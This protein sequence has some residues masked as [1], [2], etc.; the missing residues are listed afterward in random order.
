MTILLSVILVI[1]GIM[2][3]SVGMLSRREKTKAQSV[4]KLF[5][6]VCLGSALWC[7]GYA[8]MAIAPQEGSAYLLRAVALF[9]VFSC[10]ASIVRYTQ[11]MSGIYF[12]HQKAFVIFLICGAIICFVLVALPGA[13]TFVDTAYGRYYVFN[14]WIGRYTQYAYLLSLFAACL[15]MSYVWKK[16]AR[17]KREKLMARYLM[18]SSIVISA[19]AFFDTIFPLFKMPA[20]PSSAISTFI[21]IQIL[22]V[23]LK[24]YNATSVS[25]VGVSEY[26]FKTI[27]TPVIIMNE[28]M[29]IFDCNDMACGY[30]AGTK[31]EIIGSSAADWLRYMNPAD[32]ERLRVEIL[33][34]SEEI[35]V[36]TMVRGTGAACSMVSTPVYD[37]FGELLCIISILNDNT[38]YEKIRRQ[39]RESTRRAELSEAA[40]KEF[41][42]RIDK[43]I[44]API[45]DDV[46]LIEALRAGDH[47][48]SETESERMDAVLASNRDLIRSMD[49]LL[50]LSCIR[51]GDFALAHHKFD[52]EELLVE[53]FSETAETID[54]SRV[55]LITRIS[56]SV[57]KILTGDRTRLKYIFASILQNAVR[58]TNL[59]RI[60]FQL[61]CE[62][63]FGNV[64]LHVKI[65]DTGCGINEEELDSIFGMQDE[66]G[67]YIN[68][69]STLT[70]AL[71]SKLIKMMNGRIS[72]RSSVGTGTTVSFD[73]ELHTDDELGIVPYGS[74]RQKALVIMDDQYKSEAVAYTLKE[75]GMNCETMIRERIEGANL[76]EDDKVSLVLVG[77][78]ILT[79]MRAYLHQAYKYARLVPV[80]SYKNYKLLEPGDEGVCGTLLFSQIKEV[81]KR[82]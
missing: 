17:H 77:A 78:G 63:S 44:K 61:T 14:P 67:N 1:L 7:I 43:K 53:V 9:G 79:R 39:A 21:Y 82:R 3:V 32:A 48:F 28:D 80:Y 70:L 73:I 30:L 81:L 18:I 37:K 23:G 16:R 54:E 69:G 34:Q 56:P 55:R 36:R 29:S 49:E 38:E 25:S 47:E 26:I 71:C 51:S 65:S 52:I 12:K 19:G 58:Y 11:C 42:V 76:T 64:T 24:Q 40:K 20:F 62:V 57:P 46:A 60:M 35:E 45:H 75:L 50:E 72:V 15:W 8:L 66:T 4:N 68:E 59:G 13:V 41:L 31:E 27:V 10:C 74:Y 6:N 2:N 22:Y 33:N 5:F